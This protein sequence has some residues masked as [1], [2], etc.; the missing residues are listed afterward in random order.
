MIHD[1]KRVN[2][3]GRVN[4]GSPK[5]FLEPITVDVTEY[6]ILTAVATGREVVDGIGVLE[7]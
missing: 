4:R 5:V 1:G 3:P 7:A 6:D 2:M